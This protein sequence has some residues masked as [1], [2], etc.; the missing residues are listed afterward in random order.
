MTDGQIV[1]AM[2]PYEEEWKLLQTIPGLDVVSAA[3]L[4][5]EIGVDMSRFGS[6]DR[7]C[8]WAGICPGNNESAGKRRSGR[9]RKANPYVR[10]LLCEAANSARKTQSQF[11]GLYKGLVIRRGHKRAVVAVGHRILQ[12]AYT[13]LSRK[14]PYRDPEIDY[15]ALIVRRNAPRWL[16]ALEKYGYLSSIKSQV[17]H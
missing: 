6:R 7:I 13:L 4:I 10:S 15:E 5:A 1:A 17:K 8:S 9:S 16:A 12:I 2:K 3:M 14:E 11:Q